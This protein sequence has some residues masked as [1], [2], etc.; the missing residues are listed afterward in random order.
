MICDEDSFNEFGKDIET[1]VGL[2][3]PNYKEKLD[4]SMKKSK[5]KEGVITGEGRINGINSIIA[6][7]DSNFM[8]GSMG[9]VVGEK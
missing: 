8:M 1:E 9:T 6:V 2:D 3:F 5:L 7:M 4:K